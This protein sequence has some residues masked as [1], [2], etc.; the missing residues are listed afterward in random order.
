MIDVEQYEFRNGGIVSN[1]NA[2]LVDKKNKGKA[3]QDG[4]FYGQNPFSHIADDVEEVVMS[5][6]QPWGFPS[7]SS[8]RSRRRHFNRDAS[9]SSSRPKAA[10]EVVPSAQAN[11]LR[12]FKRFDTVEDF[13]DHYYAST[14]KASKQVMV[15]YIL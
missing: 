13:S 12:D 11:F 5:T 10:V 7:S 8:S 15:Y 14:G 9:S 6:T 2:N 4:S 3:I 1:N